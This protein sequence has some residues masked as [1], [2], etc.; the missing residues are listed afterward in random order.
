ML[1]ILTMQNKPRTAPN[2]AW[3]NA[4]S[5]SLVRSHK[6]TNMLAIKNSVVCAIL[7]R[8]NEK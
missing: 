5:D 1:I 6:E 7:S 3:S 2:K 4:F 8:T